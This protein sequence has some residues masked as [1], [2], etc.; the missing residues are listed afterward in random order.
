M[1]GEPWDRIPSSYRISL[2]IA[3]MSYPT[4]Q[5]VFSQKQYKY[6]CLSRRKMPPTVSGITVID[7]MKGHSI[8]I[9][10][11]P[12]HI[13][14]MSFCSQ[15]QMY[16]IQ[17]KFVGIIVSFSFESACLHLN[18]FRTTLAITLST[19]PLLTR[20]SVQICSVILDFVMP[21][22]NFHRRVMIH[23]ILTLT[24]TAV[25]FDE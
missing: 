1:D 19:K 6:L 18:V 4:E 17:M 7:S 9:F 16:N 24:I 10:D 3:I 15:V 11:R 12:V 23:L 14:P 21:L 5:S 20:S 22:S 8:L 2:L 25:D 13:S